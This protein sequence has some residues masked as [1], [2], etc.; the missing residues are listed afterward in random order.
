[1]VDAHWEDLRGRQVRYGDDS[2]ELTG[3][4]EIRESGR[5]LAVEARRTDDVRQPTA[6]LHFDVTDGP[7]SLNPGDLGEHFDRLE[8]RGGEQYIVVK[9]E[10]RTYRYRLH[11]VEPE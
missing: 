9:R 6:R 11:R 2:W 1:M 5:L 4:L 8:R 7:G 3:D 10:G